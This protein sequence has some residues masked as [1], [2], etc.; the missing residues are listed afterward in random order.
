MLGRVRIADFTH[1]KLICVIW[2][3]IVVCVCGDN[4][5]DTERAKTFVFEK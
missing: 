5:K 1:K 2:S 4:A 3:F